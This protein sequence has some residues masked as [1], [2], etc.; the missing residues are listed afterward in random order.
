MGVVSGVWCVVRG[1]RCVARGVKSCQRSSCPVVMIRLVVCAS[2]LTSQ[3]IL[4]HL[5]HPPH[6]TAIQPEASIV[7]GKERRQWLFFP[8][9]AQRLEAS[10]VPSRRFFP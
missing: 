7:N 9:K 5:E 4:A 10:G 2:G 6:S 3:R 1:V 8:P